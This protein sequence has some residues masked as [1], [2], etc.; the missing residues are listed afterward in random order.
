VAQG[1]NQKSSIDYD[2]T[3]YPVVR[4]ESVR[5]IIAL[6]AKHNLQLRQ[7]DITTAFLNGELKE[8]IFMK[9]P[10]GFE[11]KG[12]EHMVCKLKR[13]IYGLKQASRCWNQALDNHLKHMGLKPST[14]D[15]C[16][17]TMNSG[18]EF[19]ILA[20]Y[21]DDIIILVG[22]STARIQQIIK[23]IAEKFDVK[24]MGKL[25]H[26]LGVIVIHLTNGEIWIGQP[27]YT[28]EMLKSFNI[29]Q[30]RPVA[31]PVETGPKLI[32][33]MEGEELFNQE[34]YQSAVG[35]LLYLSTKTRPD[36]AYAVGNVLRFTEKPKMQH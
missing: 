16:I 24:E 2:E 5:T 28:K 25:H 13:S 10:K 27:T 6:A 31:T 34:T 11:I 15:P 19:F 29:E 12:R 1:F 36:I 33:T 20:V 8:D 3:F 32:K 21:V 23:E 17:Y 26:F 14:N 4:F 30:A 18:G 7:V 35:C 9:Q 22:K